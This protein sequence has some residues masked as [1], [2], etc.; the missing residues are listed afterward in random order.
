MDFIILFQNEFSVTE[1]SFCCAVVFSHWTILLLLIPKTYTKLGF[2]D[3]FA[4]PI[5][6]EKINE[7]FEYHGISHKAETHFLSGVTVQRTVTKS[8]TSSAVYLS[9]HEKNS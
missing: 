8:C 9:L 4:P 1:L 3:I 7:S 6:K 2:F 5:K